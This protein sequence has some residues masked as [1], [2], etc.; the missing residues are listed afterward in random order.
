MILLPVVSHV[1]ESKG[2]SQLHASQQTKGIFQEWSQLNVLGEKVIG[3]QKEKNMSLQNAKYS[4]LERNFL[5]ICRLSCSLF[6][7]Y[8]LSLL[9]GFKSNYINQTFYHSL[10]HF[11]CNK[12]HTKFIQQ[13]NAQNVSI[14]LCFLYCWSISGKHCKYIIRLY[15]ALCKRLYMLERNFLPSLWD[16]IFCS[17]E[18]ALLHHFYKRLLEWKTASDAL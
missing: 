18:I 8:S 12:I 10:L 2:R 9:D 15:W 5:S 16:Y 1:K 17:N 4:K 13:L 3:W 11:S 6:Q 14:M 7:S